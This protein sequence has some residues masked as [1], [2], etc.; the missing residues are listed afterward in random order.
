MIGALLLSTV[1]LGQLTGP[2]TSIAPYVLPSAPGVQTISLLT[3]GEYVNLKPNGMPYYMVGIPDGMG[4]FESG[5]RTFDLLLNHELG[6][7]A[8]IVRRHGFAGAFVSRWRIDRQTLRV[9]YGEDLVESVVFAGASSA[10]SRLCSGDLPVASAFYDPISQMGTAAKIYMNGE[11]AGAEGRGFAH[12]VDGP[13]GG[14]SY[15]LPRLGKM[16]WEN[17][18]AHPDAGLKTIVVALDDSSPG[19]VYVYV[20]NKQWSGNPVERAG[21]MN[22]R[23]YGIKVPNV[24]LESRPNGLFGETAFSLHDFGDVSGRTGTWLQSESVAQGVT[25]FLRPEDGQWDP[26]N[27][28]DFYFVT[29]DQFNGRSRLYRLRFEDINQPELGGEI[30]AVLNGTEGQQMFDNMTVDS[31]GNVLLQE[32]PGGND[33]LAKIWKYKI[34]NGAL[35]EVAVHNPYFFTP[36]MPGFL[37]N[38]E[39]SSGIIE[40]PKL[41]HNW[42]IINVQAHYALGGELVEGGQL[43]A[44]RIP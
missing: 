24:P 23:L 19:Q 42:Y 13:L 1:G 44:I 8:G 21:L 35:T 39:E 37:T 9:M 16:S 27:P 18:V 26:R 11:E 32:D 28:N 12:V 29:T 17:S 2:S 40:A 25:E 41:G 33:Y 30:T 6:S 36:G 14:V 7:T 5:Q 34:S 22:G 20:G 4:A 38:N 43:L 3:V 10:F 31:R 15:E